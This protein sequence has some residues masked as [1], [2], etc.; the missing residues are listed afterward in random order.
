MI[1]EI[2]GGEDFEPERCKLCG[3]DGTTGA[4]CELPCAECDGAGHT[5]NI[6][7]EVCDWVTKQN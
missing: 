4:P 6:E 2:C 7:C 5:E 1:C 3:G